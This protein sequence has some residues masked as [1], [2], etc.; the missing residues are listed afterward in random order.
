MAGTSPAMTGNRS[1]SGLHA[2]TKKPPGESPAVFVGIMLRDHTM[3]M[4]CAWMVALL[5]KVASAC[6]AAPP[7]P[8]ES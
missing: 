1:N 8:S 5:S 7:L 2:G 4:F 3:W 6:E